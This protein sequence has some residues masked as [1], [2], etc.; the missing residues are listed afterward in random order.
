MA[1]VEGNNPTL[2]RTWRYALLILGA[3]TF[4]GPFSSW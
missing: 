4:V 1:T 2:D 3:A